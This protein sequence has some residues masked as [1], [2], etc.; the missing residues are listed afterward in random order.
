MASR[1]VPNAEVLRRIRKAHGEVYDL[2]R[3]TGDGVNGKV[4]VRCREHGWVTTDLGNLIRGQ[5]A[6]RACGIAKSA[7]AKRDSKPFIE[8]MASR[9]VAGFKYDMSMY[10]SMNHNIKITCPEGHETLQTPVNHEMSFDGCSKCS[11][12]R[13]ASRWEDEVI[14]FV[15]SLGFETVRN[16]RSTIKPKELD[17]CIPSKSVAIEC[18]G[19]YYHAGRKDAHRLKWSQ[20]TKLGIRLI[21]LFEDEWSLKRPVVED[22]IRAA[23]GLRERVYARK[24]KVV[25]VKSK[26]ATEFLNRHHINSSNSRGSVRYGLTYDDKLVALITLGTPR[27]GSTAEYE[28]IRYAASCQ[29]VGGFDK[30]FRH[31][32]KTLN[33]HSVLSYADLRYGTGQQYLSAGFVER[34][35]TPPD[36]WWWKK[37]VRIPRYQTQKR[38]LRDHPQF[39][40][41]Y[42]DDKTEVEICT[43]AGFRQ[44][45]GVG[46]RVMVWGSALVDNTELSTSETDTPTRVIR[47]PQSE[48]QRAAQSAR[49]KA[50]W[51]NPEN[52]QKMIDANKMSWSNPE[53]RELR[54]KAIAESRTPEVEALRVAKST[55][56]NRT[57]EGRAKLSAA[58]KAAHQRDDVKVATKARHDERM[59]DPEKRAVWLSAIQAGR[60]AE[61]EVRRKAAAA[62]SNSKAWAD[63]EKRAARIAKMKATIAAKKV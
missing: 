48:Q 10:Q 15:E 29:V 41:F 32:V 16:D 39:A 22:L 55:A 57:P 23:L 24:C 3:I 28:V 51:E 8:R 27:F 9:I 61:S 47:K 52:K 4:E 12:G 5:G 7:A 2:S 34:G 43:A 30:L 58:I 11:S 17:V 45:W 35:V 44:I 14:A 49:S 6:C 40:E 37:D 54:L 50:W 19:L 36:Y 13:H 56:T 60:T 31:A 63:P 20:C 59:A 25:E 53:R 46:H 1:K 26:D 18:N 33:A 42:S 62:E 21:Q 38:L